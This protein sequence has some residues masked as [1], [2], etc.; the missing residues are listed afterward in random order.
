MANGHLSKK[1]L[2]GANNS[3][4][5]MPATPEYDFFIGIPE[6]Q[7][8]LVKLAQAQVAAQ[9]E[10]S[11]SIESSNSKIANEIKQFSAELD[12]AITNLSTNIT[13]VGDTI[14]SAIDSLEYSIIVFR[15]DVA[16]PAFLAY[17]AAIA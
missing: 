16:A 8:K 12:G 7:K 14:V 3:P 6:R 9:Y 2:F 17:A 11:K 4:I 5:Y 1:F 10:I 13:Q 15:I